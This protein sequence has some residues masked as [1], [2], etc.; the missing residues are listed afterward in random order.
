M[1]TRRSE[2]RPDTPAVAGLV[3][4]DRAARGTVVVAAPV[5]VIGEALGLIRT[6]QSF[7]TA[8][9]GGA[10]DCIRDTNLDEPSRSVEAH[11]RALPLIRSRRLG[12]LSRAVRRSRRAG[13]VA[14]SLKG[15]A[16]F[17]VSKWS[18]T[19]LSVLD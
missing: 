13:L 15:S 9:A 8:V 3:L 12:L 10:T 1:G 5:V 2:Y 18:G 17:S 6:R 4:D 11:Q 19:M 7:G 16:A 14:D